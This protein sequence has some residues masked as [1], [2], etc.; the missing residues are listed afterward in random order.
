MGRIEAKISAPSAA[1]T[2]AENFPG[3]VKPLPPPSIKWPG[4]AGAVRAPPQVPKAE[5]PKAAA[6]PAEKIASDQPAQKKV[7]PTSEPKP[8]PAAS[9]A[10]KFLEPVPKAPPPPK[11]V[12]QE[13]LHPPQ[14]ATTGD[15]PK[16][17]DSSVKVE[18]VKIEASTCS[19]CFAEFSKEQL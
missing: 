18:P 3:K 4:Y 16:G 2:V 14:G 9:S 5:T 1:S 10:A 8:V 6:K 13:P 11:T 12:P 7:A 15:D 19:R 17:K